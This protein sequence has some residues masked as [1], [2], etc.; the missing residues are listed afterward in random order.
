MSSISGARGVS[1][2]VLA[3]LELRRGRRGSRVANGGGSH[4][5]LLTQRFV[6][7]AGGG[8]IGCIGILT[9]RRAGAGGR[10][11]VSRGAASGARRTKARRTEL[12]HSAAC[13]VAR[14]RSAVCRKTL[15]IGMVVM[16][17]WRV[18]GRQG[19]SGG[20]REKTTSHTLKAWTGTAS[21]WLGMKVSRA[22]CASVR[23][24]R[25]PPHGPSACWLRLA[26]GGVFTSCSREHAAQR[27]PPS[28]PPPPTPPRRPPRTLPPRLDRRGGR[29]GRR[30]PGGRGDDAQ[31]ARARRELAAHA[32][33]A[34]RLAAFEQTN[35]EATRGSSQPHPRKASPTRT[36]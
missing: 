17:T 29:L 8:H 25:T 31:A 13:E 22:C 2:L 11:R 9:L 24:A 27:H 32:R 23:I 18:C 33:Q 28:P 35:S 34:R 6:A 4:I 15:Q 1:C 3:P 14:S 20:E 5:L 19:T 7:R 21:V 26:V 30:R 36:L 16:N 10:V 12:I